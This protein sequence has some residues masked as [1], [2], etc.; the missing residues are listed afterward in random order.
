MYRLTCSSFTPIS[1]WHCEIARAQLN[2]I[3]LS[4]KKTRVKIVIICFEEE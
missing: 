2:M 4:E 1:R 3:I